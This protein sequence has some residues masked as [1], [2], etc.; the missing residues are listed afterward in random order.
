MKIKFDLEASVPECAFFALYAG[1]RM[2]KE[3]REKRD[4]PDGQFSVS[5]AEAFCLMQDLKIQYPTEYAAAEKEYDEVY[6]ECVVLFPSKEL[7]QKGN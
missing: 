3:Q 2:Y 4:I 5:A 6:G 1:L 7:I